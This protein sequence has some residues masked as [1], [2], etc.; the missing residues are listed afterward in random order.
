[1]KTKPTGY[2]LWERHGIVCIVTGF[3]GSANRKTGE[4]LQTYILV[5]DVAPATARRTGQ[6]A[7]I[8][9]DC[10][11]VWCYVALHQ[12]PTSVYL[13]Y[14]RGG[15]PPID[16]CALRGRSIRLGS[17]G[18]PACVP[19]SIWDRVVAECAAAIGYTHQWRQH[20]VQ[21][22]KQYLMASVDSV[23]EQCEAAAAGWRT[24]RIRLAD[25]P[26]FA[27]EVV[28]PASDEAGHRTT[29]SRCLFCCGSGKRGKSVV[30]N[31]HGRR[32]TQFAL[33]SA[34]PCD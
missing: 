26:A 19:A 17:Y 11:R 31:A 2:V 30:I 32:A 27:D 29:C 16:W 5:A 3:G 24:F 1:M 10:P 28:C 22:L 15:Y 14:R 23:A 25:Q 18:D 21:P 6:D 20:W 12:A 8:C 9:G 33:K 34:M 4:M 7:R 13:K